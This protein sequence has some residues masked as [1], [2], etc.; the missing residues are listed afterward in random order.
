MEIPMKYFSQ[1]IE[2][3]LLKDGMDDQGN[4]REVTVPRI[5]DAIQRSGFLSAQEDIFVVGKY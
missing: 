5:N 1:T 3:L 4:E 2:I